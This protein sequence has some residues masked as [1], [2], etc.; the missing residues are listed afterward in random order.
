[1]RCTD[2]RVIRTHPVVRRLFGV[3]LDETKMV[4]ESPMGQLAPSFCLSP[5]HRSDHFYGNP[6]HLG[7][8]TDVRQS[9]VL[10]DISITPTAALI[11][12]KRHRVDL[13]TRMGISKDFDVKTLYCVRLF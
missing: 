7:S 11:S 2:Y 1:M 12:Q 3:V 10:P 9:N 5:D 4:I 13:V 6:T 8:H